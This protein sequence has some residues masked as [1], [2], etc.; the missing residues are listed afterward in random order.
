[1]DERVRW[2]NG[3]LRG[4]FSEAAIQSMPYSP[5]IDASHTPSQRGRKMGALRGW[6]GPSTPSLSQPAASGDASWP[7]LLLPQCKLG[8]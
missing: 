5:F 1:M 8:R 3:G 2:V 4:G 7:S 6:Y